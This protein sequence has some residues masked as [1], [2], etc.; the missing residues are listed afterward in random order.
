MKQLVF[1]LIS[2]VLSMAVVACKTAAPTAKNN[3]HLAVIAYY[4]GNGTDLQQYK[5]EQ[6]T[7]VIFSFC[8]LRGNRLA[9]DNST[10]ELTIRNLVALKKQHPHLKVLL[11]LG[12]WGGCETCS[13]VFSTPEGRSAFVASVKEL[14]EDYGADG[15]DLDW[16]YPAIE[17]YPGHVYKPEDKRNFTLLVQELRRVLGK[18]AEISFAAGAFAEFF[19]QS[20]EWA[21]VMPLLDRVNLMTYDFISG[22]STVTGHHTQLLSTAEQE[23]SVDYS[24]RYLKN[25]GVPPSKIVIGAAFYAR[26]WEQVE[27]VNN[28]LYQAGKFKSFVPYNKFAQNISIDQGFAFF[29]DPASQAPYAYNEKRRE[30]ATFD[31]ATSVAMKT[32][33]ARAKGLGGIMF[34]E[35]SSDV[36]ENGLLQVIHDAKTSGQ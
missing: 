15:I 10:D 18:H 4:S 13:P 6:L 8:H 17:G 7:H 5:W 32:K 16:E 3:G 25:L 12:G 22:F 24:V 26:T 33:F 35:L 36:P 11:S 14:L 34:W 21:Q 2:L 1:P 28:G 9:V 29:R 27:N 23:A 31:D 30:F 20:I 19:D